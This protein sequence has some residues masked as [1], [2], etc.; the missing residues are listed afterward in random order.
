MK[1]FA[2]LAALLLLLAPFGARAADLGRQRVSGKRIAM[3]AAHEIA[4]LAHEPN[5]DFIPASLVPDQVVSDGH[6][7]LRAQSP[8]GG[9][10]FV[11]VPVQIE[12]NGHLDR[13]VL[14]GY[15]VQQFVET[16]V[17]SQDLIAGTVLSADDLRM[18]R[19]PFEGRAGNGIDALV[20]R[21]LNGAVLEGQPV[22]LSAT[23]VNQIVKPGSTVMF[24]I[25]D[26][27]VA[28]SADAIARSGGGLGDQVFV[29]NPATHKALSGV[30]TGPG[31]VELDISGG[32]E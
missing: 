17:A 13:T 11:N 9:A 20:G 18:A 5:Q 19:V 16:A 26:D 22:A 10:A 7:D 15:R 4:G 12:V 21:R 14:V 2:A 32:T 31:T 28:V 25:R 6:V 24:I 1:L 29:Y 8:V 27:G 3:L 30:V 23:A